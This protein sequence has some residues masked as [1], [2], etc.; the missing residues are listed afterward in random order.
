MR[1]DKAVTDRVDTSSSVA[2]R[3][4]VVTLVERQIHG[5][6]HPGATH[7]PYTYHTEEGSMEKLSKLTRKH[8]KLPIHLDREGLSATWWSS[9]L[10]ATWWSSRCQNI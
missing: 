9:R 3:T 8:E 2:M 4:T 10:S 7:K 5:M 6:L 1:R